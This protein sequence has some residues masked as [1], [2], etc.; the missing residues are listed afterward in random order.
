MNWRR[1]RSD[2]PERKKWQDQEKIFSA[3]GLEQGMAFI[4]P[5]CGEGYFALP[6]SR[7]VGPGGR[8][9]MHLISTRRQ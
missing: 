7:R 5:G 1:F 6:A 8:G 2:D 3:I 9:S 4:D